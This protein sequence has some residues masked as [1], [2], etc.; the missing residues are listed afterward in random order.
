[1]SIDHP[2]PCLEFANVHLIFGGICSAGQRNFKPFLVRIKCPLGYHLGCSFQIGVGLSV[3]TFSESDAQEPTRPWLNQRPRL[4]VDVNVGGEG[5]VGGFS[6]FPTQD[7]FP[8]DSAKS[9]RD[10]QYHETAQI[11]QQDGAG[12]VKPDRI[13]LELFESHFASQMEV[14]NDANGRVMCVQTQG[15][16][17]MIP[18]VNEYYNVAHT[19]ARIASGVCDEEKLNEDDDD[20]DEVGEGENR[21]PSNLIVAVFEKVT[22]AKSRWK[23]LLKAGLVLVNNREILFNKHLLNNKRPEQGNGD[24]R[25]VSKWAVIASIVVVSWRVGSSWSA[26]GGACL[27]NLLEDHPSR[28]FLSSSTYSY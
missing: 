1:M 26:G 13:Q 27:C 5:V 16:F 24:S 9:R 23:C 19:P 8:Y 14:A 20:L 18:Q 15:S 12:D 4:G 7:F 11:P 21:E 10:A 25:R 6:P 2:H 28:K 17:P 22:R 3:L